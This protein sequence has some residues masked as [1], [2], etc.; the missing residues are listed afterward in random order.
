MSE[1]DV[2]LPDMLGTGAMMAPG[3]FLR[4]RQGT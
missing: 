1:M 2:I 3:A 4:L